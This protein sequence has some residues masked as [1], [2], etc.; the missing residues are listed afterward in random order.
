MD[1]VLQD[2]LKKWWASDGNN[3]HAVNHPLD[4]NSVV[5]ELGG[6]DGSWVSRMNPKY[7]SKYYV[8]EPIKTFYDNINNKFSSDTNIKPIQ[9]GISAEDKKSI[10]YKNGDETTLHK[11]TGTKEEIQLWSL[12]TLLENIGEDEIDFMQI[13]IEGEEY[14]LLEDLINKDVIHK[15]KRMQIQFHT[16]V[17]GYGNRR[18]KIQEGLIKCG[19]TKVYDFPFVF[20]CWEK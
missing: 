15:V 7:K 10:L 19:Y 2:S 6:F 11:Q 20:E 8:L 4:E 14:P 18:L 9:V 5:V 12:E 1:I 17:E 16:F 3:T 13:N